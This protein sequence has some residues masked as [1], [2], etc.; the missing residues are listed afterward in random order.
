MHFRSRPLSG[1]RY[2]QRS[3]PLNPRVP[4]TM[5][6]D[7]AVQKQNHPVLREDQE[8]DGEE[9]DFVPQL[10]FEAE[11]QPFEQNTESDEESTDAEEDFFAKSS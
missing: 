2:H 10:P 4:T 3:M 11:V 6:L 8:E 1:T 7:L 9:V 5:D